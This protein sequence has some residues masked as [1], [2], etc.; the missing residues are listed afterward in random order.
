MTNENNTFQEYEL[1][2]KRLQEPLPTW[3]ILLPALGATV[4]YLVLMFQRHARFSGPVWA[5][6]TNRL[7]G[8]PW[9]IL[10]LVLGCTAY[11]FLAFQ[12]RTA[13][14]WWLV[15]GP[16]VAIA[17]VYV[18]FMYYRDAHSVG[19]GWATFLGLLRSA[20]YLILAAFFLLPAKQENTR[21]EIR[22]KV[23][24]VFDVSAS[25]NEVDDV[26]NEGQDP[27]TL[28][29]R[30][31]KVLKFLS[32]GEVAFLKRLHQTNPVTC[33]RFG[34][35]LDET[36]KHYPQGKMWTEQELAEWLK[37]N[38][39]RTRGPGP[40]EKKL[41]RRL[42]DANIK[43]KDRQD[44]EAE[45]K[46]LQQ[47]RERQ[48]EL[49]RR[50]YSGTNLGDSLLQ[51]F[52]KEAA[53]MLQGIVVVSDGRSNEGK[54]QAYQ[55]LAGL[56]DKAKVPIFCIG[57]GKFK[58]QVSIKI[59]DL[60]VPSTARPDEPFPVQVPVASQGLKDNDY[61]VILEVARVEDKSGH[62]IK[63]ERYPVLKKKSKHKSD[64]PDRVEF[65]IDVADLKKI[66]ADDDKAGDL[67][68]TWEFQ[69]RVARDRREAFNKKF[70][71]TDH[72]ARVKV[73]KKKMR[74]LL[75]AGGPSKD[76]QFVQRFFYN[77]VQAERM[78]LGIYLQTAAGEEQI[79]QD[80]D[81]EWLLDQFPY[82][83]VSSRVEDRPYT[84]FDY[85]LVIAFDPDWS[86][87]PT[88]SLK[89]LEE[90]VK[91]NG[92]GLILVG[93]PVNTY[94]L[95]RPPKEP[96]M[97]PILNLY[98]VILDDARLQGLSQGFNPTERHK[99]VW[100][101]A[102]ASF[103][104]LK[105]N[106]DGEGA[107]AGWDDFYHGTNNPDK[108][109]ELVRG[110]YSY[111]P[112]EAK[113]GATVIAEFPVGKANVPYL[114]TMTPGG[115][116]GKTVFIGSQEMCRL[117]QCKSAY[118]ERFW[119][120]LARYASS[121]N[122]GSIQ[123]YG[124]ANIPEQMKIGDAKQHIEYKLRGKDRTP[125]KREMAAELRVIM[126]RFKNPSDPKPDPS[127]AVKIDLVPK[128]GA[129]DRTTGKEE[130]SGW[131]MADFT[132][133]KEGRYEFKLAIPGTSEVLRNTVIATKPNPELDNVRPDL[134]RLWQIASE[135]TEVINR[136]AR[137]ET[138][139]KL[140]DLKGP[141]E[142]GGKTGARDGQRLYFDLESAA[143]IPDCMKTDRAEPV[144][145]GDV[146]DYI[147]EGSTTGYTMFGMDVD[148]SWIMGVIVLLLSIEWLTRKLLKLA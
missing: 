111:Y 137:E 8:P 132:I 131:F 126:T 92:A 23:V 84:L 127:T 21:T 28:L 119:I 145:L 113:S 124:D 138:R 36:P 62:P 147:D 89:L 76:Y 37:I 136:V 122:R 135:N 83:R 98:P 87:V 18:G 2:L 107:T 14:G 125:M 41:A 11:L 68:G 5:R 9:A 78:E 73:L 71:V 121:G 96:D 31:D 4:L 22:S 63:G 123:S 17:F 42:E 52:N 67:E 12:L 101:N 91:D 29:S 15:L 75:F 139:A 58:P 44:L 48:E 57:V 70:H 82:L 115:F 61:E 128:P 90:W 81:K 3:A 33:Y 144:V 55:E 103:E 143:L 99:L 140:R 65:E 30:Q 148:F 86:L 27:R 69:A 141:V 80:V 20:V 47:E 1:I 94:M 72:P 19:I 85:D 60:E 104:F 74:V 109:E 59:N 6:L 106:E 88:A 53:N 54:E 146:Q 24:V 142:E 40:E 97:T 116:K 133:K 108:D 118:H 32:D 120:K 10:I 34:L 95:A 66:K 56:A 129:R 134:V 130:N 26:P 7:F 13:F 93:G 43:G 100:K 114:V 38:P 64:E 117:R 16:V 102:N 77:E 51:V 105:L 25:L 112:C 39:D 49:E 35:G 110:F 46:G 45:L 50:L 79:D